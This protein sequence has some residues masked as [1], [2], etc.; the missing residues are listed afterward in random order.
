MHGR[1]ARLPLEVEKSSPVAD[2]DIK[3]NFRLEN[4]MNDFCCFPNTLDKLTMPT[5]VATDADSWQLLVSRVSNQ[6]YSFTRYMCNFWT[7]S[8]LLSTY[9]CTLQSEGDSLQCYVCSRCEGKD[10]GVNM[11]NIRK[12]SEEM[13]SYDYTVKM[14]RCTCRSAVIALYLPTWYHHPPM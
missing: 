12:M 3:S 4:V 9:M 2:F 14:V 11:T 8:E 5:S 7:H 6:Q 1:E 13:K 10:D